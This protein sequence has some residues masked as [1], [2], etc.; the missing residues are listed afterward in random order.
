MSAYGKRCPQADRVALIVL[1][2]MSGMADVPRGVAIRMSLTNYSW[3]LEFHA[4]DADG[5]VLR[6]GSEPLEGFRSDA[7]PR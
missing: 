4:E 1:V 6:F 5:N 2:D 7:L 3:A